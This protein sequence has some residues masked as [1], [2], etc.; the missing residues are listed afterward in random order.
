[1]VSKK[2]AILSTH[3][4]IGT[5]P[6]CDARKAKILSR[7][8][9]IQTTR[10]LSNYR[11]GRVTAHT[12]R[13][14][15]LYQIS[16]ARRLDIAAAEVV[17]EGLAAGSARGSTRV[18]AVAGEG[19]SASGARGDG[20]G[21]SSEAGGSPGRGR[22]RVAAVAVRGTAGDQSGAGGGDNGLSGGGLR[23]IAIS[24]GGVMVVVVTLVLAIAVA[25]LLV[26]VAGARGDSG[27]A[28]S[29]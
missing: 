16:Q 13:A 6:A 19:H 3:M 25:L 7:K 11:Q 17:R 5:T 14:S 21:A 9:R 1:M 22:D 18:T 20:Q 29:S 26:V 2:T 23:V 12:F 24:G 4:R 28:L 10:T 8:K 15:H 27:A